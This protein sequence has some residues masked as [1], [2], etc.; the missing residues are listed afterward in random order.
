[1]SLSRPEANDRYAR[2]KLLN[3]FFARELGERIPDDIPITVTSVCPGYCSSNLL[4]NASFPVNYALRLLEKLFAYT[5]EEGSRQ[6]VW[7]AVGG[8]GKEKELQ[9]AFIARSNIAEPSD[10]VLG[11]EGKRV[12]KQLW[13]RVICSLRSFPC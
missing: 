10:Y 2:S 12:Q 5:S 11:E 6:L 3:V 4:K 8:A 7:A 9:G 13:V 1:M